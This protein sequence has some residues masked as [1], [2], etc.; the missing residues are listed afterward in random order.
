METK[1]LLDCGH[2][3]IP[4]LTETGEVFTTG[5]ALDD[6]GKTYCYNCCA[7]QDI[8][9]MREVGKIVLYVDGKFPNVTVSNWPGTLQIKASDVKYNRYGGGFGS[10]R[11]DVWFNF[12]G[13]KWHGINRGDNMLLSCKRLKKQ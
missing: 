11:T 1:E 8:K 6:E 13:E 7:E 9:Q 12:E 2:E 4:L 5:I 10:H 3:A